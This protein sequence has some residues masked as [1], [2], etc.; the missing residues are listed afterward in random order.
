[1]LPVGP[2]R[3]HEVKQRQFI[4]QP[5]PHYSS[6]LEWHSKQQHVLKEDAFCIVVRS[7]DLRPRKAVNL[8]R[9]LTCIVVSAAVPADQWM[10]G[11]PSSADR[12]TNVPPE[13]WTTYKTLMHSKLIR[14]T[15]FRGGLNAG[16]LL[17][18]LHKS[19][20]RCCWLVVWP[21][22]DRMRPSPNAASTKM[23]LKWPRPRTSPKHTVSWIVLYN[24][25]T[26]KGV[27]LRKN[28]GLAVGNNLASMP[29][30][31]LRNANAAQLFQGRKF[32]DE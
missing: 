18:R 24:H 8:F 2:P 19:V 5:C 12:W 22:N 10:L 1:M 3:R 29:A 27:V 14:T 6:Q 23:T 21:T 11:R 25:V 9:L 16:L 30:V 26:Q 28:S 31:Y 15:L 20:G 13:G 17:P 7:M 32:P 4:D